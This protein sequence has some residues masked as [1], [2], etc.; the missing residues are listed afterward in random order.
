LAGTLLSV[1]G[2]VVSTVVVWALL[3]ARAADPHRLPLLLLLVLV[4]AVAAMP[5]LAA[6]SRRWER[7]ADRHAVAMTNAAVYASAL[8]RLAAGNL[9]DLDPPTLIYLFLFTH[10]TAAERLAATGA[11]SV[12]ARLAAAAPG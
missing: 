9:G 2:A 4:L 5:A 6:I 7:S 3:G 1:A 12:P 8:R 10:P 11:T